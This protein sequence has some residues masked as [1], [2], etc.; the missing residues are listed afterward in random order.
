M[1][2]NNK[3]NNGRKKN[4]KISFLLLFMFFLTIPLYRGFFNEKNQ[5]TNDDCEY[6]Q[7]SFNPDGDEIIFISGEHEDYHIWLVD[8]NGNNY[9]QIYNDSFRINSA[10]FFPNGNQIIFSNKDGIWKMDIDGSNKTF[11][12]Q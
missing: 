6:Y 10:T 3:Y 8:V 12:C 2:N 1:N 4:L 5:I 9:R 11:L 7:P